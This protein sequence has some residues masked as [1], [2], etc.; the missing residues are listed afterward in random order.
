MMGVG[1]STIGH[2]LARRLGRSFLDTDR[3]I[4]RIEG[5]TIATIF[6]E[7]GEPHFRAIESDLIERLTKGHLDEGGDKGLVIAL[8]GGAIAR[9]GAVE[10][11]LASGEV[12]FLAAEPE[13]LLDR[14]GAST[15]RPLLAGLDREGQLA[16]LRALSSERM[17]FYRRAQLHVDASGGPTEVVDRIV[18]QL[19]CD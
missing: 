6:A 14:M 17:P 19:A 2:A 16:R 15:H 4:E 11:L 13:T 8:G 12:V 9:P 3:E 7:E 5:R 1:K 10:R 18:D